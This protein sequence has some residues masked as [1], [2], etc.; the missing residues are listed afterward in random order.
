MARE[1]KRKQSIF[2]GFYRLLSYKFFV[3][4]SKRVTP[5]LFRISLLLAVLGL[6][7]GL[8]Y[9][10]ADYQQGNSFRIIYIHVPA[11][12]FSTLVYLFMA[13]MS[14]IYLIWRIKI[15]VILAR[16]S[17]I[18]GAY[19]TLVT[20]VTGAIWGQPTWGTWWEWDIRLTSQL[21]LFFLYLGYIAL[22]AAFDEREKA[23]QM[24]SL[25]SLIGVVMVPIIK[26]SVYY[27]ESIHQTS[28]LFAKGG[29]SMPAVMLIPL[30]TMIAATFVFSFAYVGKKSVTL[31]YKERLQRHY[32]NN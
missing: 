14:A 2:V 18:L 17:A 21:I 15:A 9:A 3:P 10:P 19:Y 4:F 7:M 16:A 23:D 26:F 20:L 28:T 12:I 5:S 22:D 8:L 11:A 30:L 29:P 27:F 6:I 24:I 13:V 31:I 1:R 32:M 25:L